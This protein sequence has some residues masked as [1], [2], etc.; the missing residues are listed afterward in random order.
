MSHPLILTKVHNEE[1][2]TSAF[3]GSL[4]EQGPQ[5]IILSTTANLFLA[6]T[7]TGVF[8]CYL[9]TIYFMVWSNRR[10]KN[11]EVEPV[12]QV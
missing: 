10:N 2:M 12:E 5:G 3:K 1:K 6:G 8:S 7:L 9:S 4:K 11:T